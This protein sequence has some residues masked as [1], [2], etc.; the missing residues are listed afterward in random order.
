M[1]LATLLAAA[2]LATACATVPATAAQPE[3]GRPA[4]APGDENCDVTV[5]F[6]SYA[7]GIDSETFTRVEAYLKRRAPAVTANT[8]SWGREGERTICVTTRTGKMTRKVFNDIRN[9]TPRV[10]RRGPVEIRSRFGTFQS[11]PPEAMRR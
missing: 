2:A 4:I 11:R 8:T 5:V 1:R 3:G 10:A 6:G 9:M 7:M